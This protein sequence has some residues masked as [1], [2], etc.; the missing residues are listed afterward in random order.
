M[1]SKSDYYKSLMD[2]YFSVNDFE[3]VAYYRTKLLRLTHVN[4]KETFVLEKQ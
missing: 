4:Y 3:M 1:Q 2:Y